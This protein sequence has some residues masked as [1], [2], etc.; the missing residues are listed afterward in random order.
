MEHDA[1]GKQI[2]EILGRNMAWIMRVIEHA[3]ERFPA[4]APIAKKMT[5][6]IR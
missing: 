6:F 5:N 1:E 3:K 4:P 2:M